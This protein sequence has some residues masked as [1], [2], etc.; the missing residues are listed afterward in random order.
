[1]FREIRTSEKITDR[2]EENENF[3][4]IVPQERHSEK[5]VDSFWA[6]IF[7]QAAEEANSKD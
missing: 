5:E 3:K 6:S 7:A 4:K 2:K 1:M